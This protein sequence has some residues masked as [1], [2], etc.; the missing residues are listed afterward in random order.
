MLAAQRLV[1]LI[2]THSEGLAASLLERTKASEKTRNY[3]D[4]VPPDD[5]RQRVYE[6]Y[7]HLGQWLITKKEA[8]VEERYLEIGSRRRR[9]GVLLSQ[10]LWAILLV[11][12]NLMDFLNREAIMERP[13]EVFGELEILQLLDQFFERAVYYA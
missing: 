3:V 6:I 1:R 10:L 2:E 12:D 7:H 4:K 8:D 9:Q 13:S 5:L 11:R